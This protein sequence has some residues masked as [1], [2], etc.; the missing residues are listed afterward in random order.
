MQPKLAA[1]VKCSAEGWITICP[2]LELRAMVQTT[3]GTA[4]LPTN[5]DCG[6]SSTL[7]VALTYILLRVARRTRS[8]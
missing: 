3:T 5:N 7:T 6:F 4:H 2:H 1:P 8:G